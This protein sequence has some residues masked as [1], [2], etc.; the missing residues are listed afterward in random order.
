[1]SHYVNE[2]FE[3]SKRLV[4]KRFDKK[5]QVAN[6]FSG[7]TILEL[8]EFPTTKAG[9][10]LKFNLNLKMHGYII[11][12]YTLLISKIIKEFFKAVLIKQK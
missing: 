6:F 3:P 10:K 12:I 2:R 8:F 9:C 7:V 1:M 11:P 4:C 5:M